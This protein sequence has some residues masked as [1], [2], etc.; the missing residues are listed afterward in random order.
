MQLIGGIKFLMGGKVVD[1]HLPI[2]VSV[3]FKEVRL[4][5]SLLDAPLMGGRVSIADK[6]V[7]G[8][9]GMR[10]RTLSLEFGWAGVSRVSE[11]LT[12]VK[13]TWR[14]REEN[15]EW[16][17]G[18]TLRCNEK[19]AQGY[20]KRRHKGAPWPERVRKVLIRNGMDGMDGVKDADDMKNARVTSEAG[21]GERSDRS[22]RWRRQFRSVMGNGSMEKIMSQV[23][24]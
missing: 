4:P 13:A 7:T 16:L 22:R 6:G 11:S 17:T 15:F 9:G 12:I 8:A 5:L 19:S 23:L 10:H 3:A 2:F 18:Y 20:E 14:L 1:P 24:L 21:A